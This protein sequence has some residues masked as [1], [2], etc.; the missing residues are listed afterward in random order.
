[1]YMQTKQLKGFINKAGGVALFF[2]ILTASFPV[3]AQVNPNNNEDIWEDGQY[4]K[5]LAPQGCDPLP[6]DLAMLQECTSFAGTDG[7]ATIY[8]ETR[9]TSTAVGAGVHGM[10][11]AYNPTD[12][13]MLVVST[14]QSAT[15]ILGQ[16]FNAKTLQP[17]SEQFVID[18]GNLDSSS[19]NAVYNPDVNAYLVVWQDERP[20]ASRSSIYARKVEANGSLN[21]PDFP[22]VND[23]NVRL[24]D[25][26]LDQTNNRYSVGYDHVPSGPAVKT[27]DFDGTVQGSASIGQ[28]TPHM[29]GESSVAY[30]SN[31]NEYWTTYV[32]VAG[33]AGTKDQDERIMFS[34]MDAATLR[35]VG[36][37]V[38]LSYTRPGRGLVDSPQISY[39]AEDGAALIVWRASL[40][41]QAGTSEIFGKTISDDL[42]ISSEHQIL[43]STTQT[44]AMSYGQPSNFKYNPYTNTFG[45]VIEDGAG[46]I[47]YLE[48]LSSGYVVELKELSGPSAVA[49]SGDPSLGSTSTGFVSYAPGTA[50]P[51]TVTSLSS[52]F[53]S[54][55]AAVAPV[56][57]PSTPSA[58]VDTAKFAQVLSRI[59]I[60]ALGISGLFAV[61]MSV[62]GGYLVMSAR[63][64]GAQVSKGKDYIISSLTGMVLLMASFLILNTINPDL[65]NFDIAS[66][67]F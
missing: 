2:V 14:N 13:T 6:E 65:I 56:A 37:P 35:P 32:T 53:R 38:Q 45:L 52:S 51:A 24:G 10:S 55:P 21:G 1:M 54:S 19:P 31:L 8:T 61:A 33:F 41:T 9:P 18:Q 11:S 62:F 28:Q 57:A 29:L 47:T 44:G 36:E 64:N 30:N 4:T 63:G 46:G 39:S 7:Q 58:L 26:I 15:Q 16:V 50:R 17:V 5:P 49:P 20:A 42:G 23:I 48:L 25:V 67:N 22:I 43:T 27:V 60:F 66:L 12:D 59:Y 40:R 3:Q 34:R